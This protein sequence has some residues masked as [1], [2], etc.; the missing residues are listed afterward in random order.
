[1][2]AVGA[3]LKSALYLF[4]CLAIANPSRLTIQMSAEPQ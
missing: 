1:M 3:V 2:G 4:L